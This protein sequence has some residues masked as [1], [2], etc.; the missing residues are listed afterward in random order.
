MKIVMK[1]EGLEKFSSKD[2]WEWEEIL[3]GIQSMQDEIDSLKEELEDIKQD[4]KDNYKPVSY[5]EQVGYNERDF[6]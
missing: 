4:V 3:E 5:A 6:Y 2:I 1:D